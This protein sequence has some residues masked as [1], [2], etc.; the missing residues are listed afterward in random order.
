MT[1]AD[2]I[3]RH[4]QALGLTTRDLADRAQVNPNNLAV[5]LAGHA[6]PCPTE[7]RCL[8]QALGITIPELLADEADW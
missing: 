2:T 6:R 5:Y 8:A 1:L 7:Q 3:A 4:A